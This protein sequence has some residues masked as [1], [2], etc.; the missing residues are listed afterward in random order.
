[1]DAFFSTIHGIIM[2][3]YISILNSSTSNNLTWF[4]YVHVPAV[5]VG[6][7]LYAMVSFDIIFSN[8]MS[9][10]IMVMIRFKYKLSI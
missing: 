1:M 8:G 10:F 7:H 5:A 2:T 9:D 3:N 6:S 4:L